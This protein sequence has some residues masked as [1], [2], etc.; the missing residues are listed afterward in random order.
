M[1]TLKALKALL[2]KVGEHNS[3]VRA[4]FIGKSVTKTEKD[5]INLMSTEIDTCMT[6]SKAFGR[7][8]KNVVGK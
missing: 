8:Y 3:T 6:T 1:D 5:K 7:K 2:E 4:Q